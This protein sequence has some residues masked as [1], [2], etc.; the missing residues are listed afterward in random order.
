MP[1]YLIYDPHDDTFTMSFFP[2]HV[3]FASSS[4]ESLGE[5]ERRKNHFPVAYVIYAS[6]KELEAIKLGFCSDKIPRVHDFL[7]C[8]LAQCH[9]DTRLGF[10]CHW[11]KRS[12]WCQDVMVCSIPT[13]TINGSLYHTRRNAQFI[14]YLV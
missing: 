2:T 11:L 7:L 10:G 5:R 14:P 8:Y 13:I 1:F 4:M 6:R 12:W 9:I 3:L